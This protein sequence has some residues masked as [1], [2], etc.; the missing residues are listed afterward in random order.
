MREWKRNKRE[1]STIS[2]DKT[3]CSYIISSGSYCAYGRWG[4]IKRY[5]T[6]IKLEVKMGNVAEDA[7]KAK[8][9][10]RNGFEIAYG[11]KDDRGTDYPNNDPMVIAAWLR[12]VLVRCMLVDSGC[13]L[14]LP[15]KNSSDKM[16]FLMKDLR[17]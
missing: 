17:A 7:Y 16:R 13:S 2:D 5:A 9:P 8:Q 4:H 14:N 10:H 1:C 15:Y 11:D 6:S 3:A 12:P